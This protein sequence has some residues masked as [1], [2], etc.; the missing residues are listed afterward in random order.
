MLYCSSCKETKSK[1]FFSFDKTSK[2]REGRTYWCK[3]CASKKSRFYYKRSS[4]SPE[5]KLNRNA[6]GRAVRLSVKQKA[7]SLLGNQ[8]FDCKQSFPMS[9]YDFHHLYPNKKDLTIGKH[10]IWGEKLLAELKKCI[11]LCANCH[12]I[13]HFEED[14]RDESID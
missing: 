5:W 14:T 6:Q 2:K 1:E 13:R 4:A 8:C 3:T 9:V 7:V 12:R 10:K 11:L